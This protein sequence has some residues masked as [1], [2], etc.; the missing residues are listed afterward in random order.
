MSYHSQK[1]YRLL[2]CWATPHHKE[3]GLKGVETN[4]LT[5]HKSGMCGI[6]LVKGPVTFKTQGTNQIA[7]NI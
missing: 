3:G 1:A 5:T 6:V 4:L 2:V 7:Q